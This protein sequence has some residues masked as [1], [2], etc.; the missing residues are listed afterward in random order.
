[1]FECI[2][3]LNLKFKFKK[4]LCVPVSKCEA[5]VWKPQVEELVLN[6]HKILAWKINQAVGGMAVNCF[7]AETEGQLSFLSLL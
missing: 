4:H 6:P 3:H 2:S 7:R 5:R 1:M